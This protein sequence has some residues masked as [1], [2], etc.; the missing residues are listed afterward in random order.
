MGAARQATG[1][2]MERRRCGCGWYWYGAEIELGVQGWDLCGEFLLCFT[3]L[4]GESAK[5]NYG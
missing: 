2:H 4:E 3:V 1:L 5:C